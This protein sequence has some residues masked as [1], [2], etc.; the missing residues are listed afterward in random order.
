MLCFAILTKCDLRNLSQIFSFFQ[1]HLHVQRSYSFYEFDGSFT[2][3]Q[4]TWNFFMTM[5]WASQVSIA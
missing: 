1:E 2:L 4:I 3:D 5:F